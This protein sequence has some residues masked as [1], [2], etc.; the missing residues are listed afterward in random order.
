MLAA[1][2]IY[3]MPM[4]GSVACGFEQSTT[5]QLCSH[6]TALDSFPPFY[7]NH[8]AFLLLI[9]QESYRWDAVADSPRKAIDIRYRLLDYIYTA[10]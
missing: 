7:R 8:D 2:A 6:W 4:V 10:F 1:A 5:E 3:Q 9:S